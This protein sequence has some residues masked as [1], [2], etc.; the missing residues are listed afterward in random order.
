MLRM[1]LKINR[2][3]ALLA[4]FGVLL[5]NA[6]HADACQN[7]EASC[8]SYCPAM[9]DCAVPSTD[10]RGGSESSD[11]SSDSDH[12]ACCVAQHTMIVTSANVEFPLV[13]VGA[14]ESVH[15]T[16]NPLFVVTFERP[17]RLA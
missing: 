14:L 8:E 13:L 4:L 11:S 5:L 15:V 6:P 17:P 16:L 10:D 7:D 12:L 9:M 2:L 3:A 1:C